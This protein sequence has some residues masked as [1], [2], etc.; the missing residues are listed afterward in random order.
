MLQTGRIFDRNQG[1]LSRI[2]AQLF[3]IEL[4]A[5]GNAKKVKAVKVEEKPKLTN[6]EFQKQKETEKLKRKK[7]KQLSDIETEIDTI[8]AKLKTFDEQIEKC[9]YDGKFD[10]I[11]PLMKARKSL[12][13]DLDTYNEKY[14][15]LFEEILAL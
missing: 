7:E 1:L 6:D 14:E 13:Q 9:S 8:K 3:S 4:V 2:T 12:E 15:L 11:E 10:E 5:S